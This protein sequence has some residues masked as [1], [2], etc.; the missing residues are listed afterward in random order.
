MIEERVNHIENATHTDEDIHEN[1]V[2]VK[3][4]DV[5]QEV[6]PEEVKQEEEQE[7]K[8]KAKPKAKSKSKLQQQ[9][10]DT[11]LCKAEIKEI[12]DIYKQFDLLLTILENTRIKR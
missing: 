7:V 12:A 5:K 9:G 8:P 3:Q 4:D 2:E 10:K 1:K 6:K 11:K